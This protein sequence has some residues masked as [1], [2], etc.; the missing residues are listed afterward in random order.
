MGEH[1]GISWCDHT[2]NPWI[3]CTKVSD[4]CTNCYAERENIHY[5]WVNE[6]GVNGNRQRTS[7]ANWRNPIKWNKGLICENC[8]VWQY[9]NKLSIAEG[10]HGYCAFCNKFGQFHRPRVFCASLSDV[11]EDRP[12]L[13]Q[14]R[15]DLWNLIG[16]TPNLDWLILT[17]RPEN[18]IPMWLSGLYRNMRLPINIWLGI[19][20]ENQ[21]MA[22]K[23]IP[24]FLKIPVGIRFLSIEP[25]LGPIDLMKAFTFPERNYGERPIEWIIC[26]GESGQNARPL[27]MDWVKQLQCD[28]KLYEIPFFF[29]QV[30]GIKR[31]NGHWGGELLNGIKYQEFPKEN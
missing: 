30:G 9:R 15:C 21:E 6:W 14:W 4:G 26:G 5:Q 12:E 18:V 16:E 8:G 22:E 2:F 17:K 7:V 25:M 3:G 20:A 11:F 31:I 24:E 13:V 28:C 19:T 29:K 27:N 23:R 1:T 10:R